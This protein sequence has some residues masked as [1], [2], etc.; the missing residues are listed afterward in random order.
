MVHEAKK[1]AGA[2]DGTATILSKEEF[3][4]RFLLTTQPYIPK[5]ALALLRECREDIELFGLEYAQKKWAK[6]IGCRW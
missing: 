5:V 1:L 6:F 2:K 4:I 3:N